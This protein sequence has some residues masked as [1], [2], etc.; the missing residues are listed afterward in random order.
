[1]ER[2]E[3]AIPMMEKKSEIM[4]GIKSA[5]MSREN[6]TCASTLW[7][8]FKNLYDCEVVEKQPVEN[9]RK[10]GRSNVHSKV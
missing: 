5:R 10:P 9:R 1:M 8:Y 4:K 7:E 6:T 3:K 2:G